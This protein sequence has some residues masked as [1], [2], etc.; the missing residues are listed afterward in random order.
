MFEDLLSSYE[1]NFVEIDVPLLIQIVI[2]IVSSFL[3]AFFAYYFMNRHSIYEKEKTF[4]LNH[5]DALFKIEYNLIINLRIN[6]R[7][8]DRLQFYSQAN[9]NSEIPKLSSDKYFIKWEIVENLRNEL[10]MEKVV[11]ILNELE[12]TENILNSFIKE[13][14]EQIDNLFIREGTNLISDSHTIKEFE[15][16]FGSSKI[17]IQEYIKIFQKNLI[18][19]LASI[20]IAKSFH[21][22]KY[23]LKYKTQLVEIGL[24]TN[25]LEDV[26]ERSKTIEKLNNESNKS[27][28]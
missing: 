15:I 10:L 9:A 27:A 23:V 21:K 6:Q 17:K 22:K 25:W 3:G 19:A 18:N 4:F 26:E 20:Q 2:P 11:S 1:I 12:S 7:N 28:S 8:L 13:S 24:E 16:Y 5:I 14:K